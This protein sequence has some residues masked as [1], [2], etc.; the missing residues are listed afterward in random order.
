MDLSITQASLYLRALE[1]RGLLSVRRRSRWVYYEA[2]PAASGGAAGIL[3]EALRISFQDNKD[4]TETIFNLATAFTHPR[5]I[6]IFRALQQPQNFQDLQKQTRVPTRALERHLRKLE[7]RDFVMRK[8]DA[9]L[10]M[11]QKEES[12]VQRALAQMALAENQIQS[13]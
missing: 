12:V 8:A 11:S 13:L 1:A 5:R 4:S 9:Y 6:E 10:G 7:K 2:P 3:V